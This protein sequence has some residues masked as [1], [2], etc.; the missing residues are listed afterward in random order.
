[1]TKG[2]IGA[3]ESKRPTIFRIHVALN[4]M[5]I[6]RAR[7]RRKRRFKDGMVVVSTDSSC[8][9]F[10]SIGRKRIRTK[11]RTPRK[12]RQATWHAMHLEIYRGHRYGQTPDAI[13][14]M[15]QKGFIVTRHV[16]DPDREGS[17]H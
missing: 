2:P 11:F 14:T 12:P 3:S 8:L 17:R 9:G 16:A 5:T 10:V 4:D 6:C 15:D 13:A 7:F 1:M